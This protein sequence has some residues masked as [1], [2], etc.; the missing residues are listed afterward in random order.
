MSEFYINRILKKM[1]GTNDENN[2]VLN[3]LKELTE[4]DIHTICIIVEAKGITDPDAVAEIIN[5]LDSYSVEFSVHNDFDLG[6]YWINC[7]C[8]DE[9]S[10]LNKYR[11]YIDYEHLAKDLLATGIGEI[12]PYG[13]MWYPD[14][15]GF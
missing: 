3:T 6:R 1:T 8:C 10:D 15:N 11:Y 14:W 12:T 5:N 9:K 7:I 4:D 13:I 2:I